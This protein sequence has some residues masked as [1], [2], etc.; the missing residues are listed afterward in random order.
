MQ[1]STFE[2]D[3][4][5][6][7]LETDQ[8]PPPTAGDASLTPSSAAGDANLVLSSATHQGTSTTG[9]HALPP[10]TTGDATLAPS[11]DA[12]DATLAPSSAEALTAAL[13][14]APGE[15]FASEADLLRRVR[16]LLQPE[17]ETPR[18]SRVGSLTEEADELEGSEKEAASQSNE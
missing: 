6:P 3:H 18:A 15:L 17:G 11:S 10:S 16:T 12:G 7:R 14:L 9:D 5:A 1:S 8:P 13:G 2:N 4:S